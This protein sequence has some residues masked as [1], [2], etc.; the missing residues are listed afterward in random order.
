MEFSGLTQ[1][2]EI[3]Q[4]IGDHQQDSNNGKAV[5]ERSQKEAAK[6]VVRSKF[7]ALHVKGRNKEPQSH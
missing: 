7:L 2:L 6:A 5:C 1:G 3:I 4:R